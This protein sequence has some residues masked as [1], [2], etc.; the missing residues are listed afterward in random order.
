MLVEGFGKRLRAARIAAGLTQ[1]ELAQRLG[2]SR[3]HLAHVEAETWGVTLTSL[4][5]LCRELHVSADYLL[6]LP[7]EK[8]AP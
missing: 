6:G 1:A 3:P 8:E 4:C 5:A 7:D 2:R